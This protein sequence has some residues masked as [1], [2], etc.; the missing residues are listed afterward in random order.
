M[1][2]VCYGHSNVL[3]EEVLLEV[4]SLCAGQVSSVS[5][6][7]A[8]RLTMLTSRSRERVELPALMLSFT[9]VTMATERFT[10]RAY[11]LV[12]PRKPR[13]AKM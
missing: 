9:M 11:K 7:G 8:R 10:R 1:F 2:F 3:T 6:A 4:V 12:R 5:L 13:R